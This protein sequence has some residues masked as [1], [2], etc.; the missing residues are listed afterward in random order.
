MKLA[1]PKHTYTFAGGTHQV[2]HCNAGEGLPRHQ[3]DAPHTHICHAGRTAV[4]KENFYREFGPEDNAIVLKAGEWHE[5][6]A[7]V[8]GTRFENTMVAGAT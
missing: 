6:E 7:L 1:A 4:R 5:I 3:H 8:D 2:Y